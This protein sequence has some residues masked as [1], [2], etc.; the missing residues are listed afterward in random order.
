MRNDGESTKEL[1]NENLQ[2]NGKRI[3]DAGVRDTPYNVIADCEAYS[4]C[5]SYH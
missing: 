3:N 1:K 4:T 5:N 2:K